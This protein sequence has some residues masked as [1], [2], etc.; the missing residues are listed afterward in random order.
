ML[1]RRTSTA[2]RIIRER[3]LR[4]R[5]FPHMAEASWLIL[6]D[7]YANAERDISVTSACT[8]SFVPA[9]TA[10]RHIALLEADGLIE[11]EADSADARRV[12]LRLTVAGADRLAD[13]F[14]A[15]EA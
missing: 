8:A 1:A 4:A 5:F 15:A 11:R 9:T 13:F 3:Y 12:W 7:L 10:L 2:Q 6:L 14:N